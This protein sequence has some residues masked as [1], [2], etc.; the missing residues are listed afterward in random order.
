[1]KPRSDLRQAKPET[2][3]A[4]RKPEGAGDSSLAARFA[5]GAGYCCAFRNVATSRADGIEGCAPLRVTEIAA[6]AAAY[7]AA[8]SS[9]INGLH[10][11][12]RSHLPR[13]VRGGEI[14]FLRAHFN[15][16]VF[17]PALEQQI[18]ALYS[19]S[20]CYGFARV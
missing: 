18:G 1:M 15:Q 10:V 8:C 19:R 9:R 11:E 14:D 3:S 20:G 4:Q 17:R 6:T 2:H 7:R 12:R 13:A 5:F 16:H